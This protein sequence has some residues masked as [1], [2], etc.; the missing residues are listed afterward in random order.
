MVRPSDGSIVTLS[1]VVKQEEG[2]EGE[3]GEEKEKGE[4][5]EMMMMKKETMTMN[6]GEGKRA[7]SITSL[8]DEVLPEIDN[9]DMYAIDH[10]IT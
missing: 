3:E 4:R 9:E 8:S 6:K 7:E 2:E 1:P 5:K 10:P